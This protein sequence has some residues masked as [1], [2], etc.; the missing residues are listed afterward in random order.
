MGKLGFTIAL[1]TSLCWVAVPAAGAHV[2]IASNPNGDQVIFDSPLFQLSRQLYA[3]TRAPGGSFTGLAPITP[4]RAAYSGSPFVDDAGGTLA[5]VRGLVFAGDQPAS[6]TSR[7]LA[8]QPG[9]AFAEEAELPIGEDGTPRLAVGEHGDALAVWAK[10]STPG[11]Y[12]FRP[13]DGVLGPETA[14]PGKNPSASFVSIEGDGTAVYLWREGAANPADARTFESERPP[15][16]EF[17]PPVEVSGVPAYSDLTATSARN[18]RQLV[19]WPALRSIRGVERLPGGR[20][21]ASFKVADSPDVSSNIHSVALA[22]SGAAAIV[23]GDER[24]F[25]AARD[26]G[27]SF[28]N[29]QLIASDAK[30]TL[31]P[32]AQVDNAGDVAVAWFARRRRVMATYRPAGGT[33]QQTRLIAREAPV[34]PP[35][36][37]HPGLAIDPAGRATVA[38]EESDGTTIRTRVRDFDASSTQPTGRVGAVPSFVRE[39]PPEACRPRG[40]TVLLASPQAIVFGFPGSAYACLLARGTPVPLTSLEEPELQVQ[41]V[42]AMAL[43]GPLL[44]YASDFIGH[45]DYATSMVVTDLRDPNSGAN[46]GTVISG[47]NDGAYVLATRLRPNGAVAWI[48]CRT[49]YV[50]LRRCARPGATRKEV[51]GWDSAT[52]QPRRLDAGRGIDVRTF[53]LHGS[54]LTWRNAGKLHH[55]RLR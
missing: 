35:Q 30:I 32:L 20:F 39:A 28:G 11:Q 43:A 37:D 6:G 10:H 44:A 33:V 1:V 50:S 47:P 23:F 54:R 55:A 53:M 16:G 29:Q 40:A 21:G 27:M 31:D 45:G 14:L 5:L 36:V 49:T 15:G 42:R 3:A 18:G 51:V 46:R 25:L 13:A 7:L 9:G 19:V 12:R 41:P 38:W 2:E 26:P 24:L 22:N 17:G 4:A 8:R 48:D 52:Q 34:A